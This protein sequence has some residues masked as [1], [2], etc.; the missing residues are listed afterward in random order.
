MTVSINATLPPVMAT[1]LFLSGFTGDTLCRVYFTGPDG[2]T[3]TSASTERGSAG[4]S[5]T[6][7]LTLN[8][9]AL[10]PFTTYYYQ[11][12]LQDASDESSCVKVTGQFSTGG[13]CCSI[14]MPSGV[15]HG[16]NS[17]LL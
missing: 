6:V 9:A 1:C 3:Y 7:Q 5:V 11:A 8:G 14:L 2:V 15:S 16:Y 13:M 10:L 4:E 17:S 12:T